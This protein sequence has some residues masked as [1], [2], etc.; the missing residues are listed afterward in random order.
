MDNNEDEPPFEP[1]VPSPEKQR[2]CNPYRPPELPFDT[3]NLTTALQCGPPPL[4]NSTPTRSAFSVI[5]RAP[6]DMYSGNCVHTQRIP[7][8]SEIFRDMEGPMSSRHLEE[9]DSMDW[10]HDRGHRMSELRH[11]DESMQL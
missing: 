4:L 6:S 7:R 1:F 3:S 10:M 9:R 8:V 11:H 5:R 2:L